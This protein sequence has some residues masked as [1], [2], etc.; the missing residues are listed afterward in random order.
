ML[1]DKS[2]EDAHNQFF[3]KHTKSELLKTFA[4]LSMLS[5]NHGKYNRLQIGTYNALLSPSNGSNFTLEQLKE[6]LLKEYSQPDDYEAP[7]N[8]FSVNIAAFN[9]NH[10]VF[11]GYVTSSPF[12]LSHLIDIV[13]S[14][15]FFSDD[16]HFRTFKN[17]VYSSSK[18]LLSLSNTIALRL[19]IKRNENAA[20][21]DEKIFVPNLD[22]LNKYREAITIT[23]DDMLQLMMQNRIDPIQADKLTIENDI[24]YDDKA[25]SEKILFRNGDEFIVLAPYHICL[26]GVRRII[27]IANE[28]GYLSELI[29]VYHDVVMG[30][31]GWLL[32]KMNFEPLFDEE[33]YTNTSLSLKE[34]FFKIDVDKLVYFLYYYDDY[35]NFNEI[36]FGVSES[37]SDTLLKVVNQ[38]EIKLREL[39]LNPK[40]SNYKILVIKCSSDLGRNMYEDGS[41]SRGDFEINLTPWELEV[42][43][44]SQKTDS[45]GIWKYAFA[46]KQKVAK[47]LTFLDAFAFYKS[48][49]DSFYW[50]DEVEKELSLLPGF[51]H[52]FIA[53]S[54]KQR[55]RHFVIYGLKDGKKQFAIVERKDR[56]V[57][58]YYS[59]A[60]LGR[61]VEFLLNGFDVPIWLET[62]YDF[63]TLPSSSQKITFDLIN[64]TAYWLW[65]ARAYLKNIIKKTNK[66]CLRII[67]KIDDLDKFSDDKLSPLLRNTNL[68]HKFSYRVTDNNLE[69]I[70]PYEISGVVNLPDNT[71][72]RFFIKAL[73]KSICTWANTEMKIGQEI[74]DTIAPLG[75]KK[76]MYTL[77]PLDNHLLW[78]VKSKIEFFTLQKADEQIIY[79]QL[80]SGLGK[81]RPAVG[82]IS[83]NQ[84]K[85]SLIRSIIFKVL[86]PWLKT[87]IDRY[88]STSLLQAFVKL[89]EEAILR[90]EFLKLSI[91]TERAC[92]G[93]YP[94]FELD[95]K[96][97]DE[98]LDKTSMSLRCLI[99]HVA[100][101]QKRGK[102]EISQVDIQQALALMSHIINFGSYVDMMYY[103][104]ED[105]AKVSI[106]VLR[107]GRVGIK[108]TLHEELFDSYYQEILEHYVDSSIEGFAG[109][110]ESR[111][112]EVKDDSLLANQELNEAFK[113]VNGLRYFSLIEILTNLSFHYVLIENTDWIVLTPTDLF[114]VLNDLLEGTANEDDV[115]FLMEHFALKHRGGVDKVPKGFIGSD[116]SPWQHN[117]RLSLLMR[118]FIIIGEESQQKIA[119]GPKQLFISAYFIVD[120]I[121]NGRLYAP[122]KSEL[123]KV[124]AKISQRE[125]DKLNENVYK[126]LNSWQI[127]KLEMNYNIYNHSKKNLKE[128]LGDV[129]V[130]WLNNEVNTI[131]SIECKDTYGGK[132]PFELAGEIQKFFK[133]EKNWSKKHLKRDEWLKANKTTLTTTFGM[134]VT[135]FRIQS[136]IVTGEIISAGHHRLS[137]ETVPI[138]N[139]AQLRKHGKQ[140]LYNLL[141]LEPL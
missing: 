87:I 128:D 39:K 61:K 119:F 43:F 107:S 13:F 30:N 138:F 103:C 110:F 82:E 67:L 16:D 73:L 118:P 132:N 59:K 93:H 17:D 36:S 83:S 123:S 31:C 51:A 34:S 124:I 14:H 90:R 79:D 117:R 111:N 21:N 50:D 84:E 32:H 71:A 80:L 89:N 28:H 137:K 76:K 40:W 54:L 116:I 99:E 125:N 131:F 113:K 104:S 66:E 75:F 56:F 53:E 102:T 85:Q 45:L 121:L 108:S 130:L 97:R 120:K 3:L 42:L 25:L 70:L 122:A 78:K 135:N 105:V 1:Q 11:P 44:D 35:E 12:W 115:T 26:S 88:D 62:V 101:D 58:L 127:G 112:L 6:F 106:N 126:L 69:F 92:F 86:L 81:D 63:Y 64:L 33:L 98:R 139:I 100:A 5:E 141:K 96:E 136:V 65:E 4:A 15:P 18:F 7:E 134:D 19:K 91:T 22:V 2:T 9:L 68:E 23:N 52:P 38:E 140:V 94:E 77:N 47:S 8:L 24:P 27:R 129:D 74:I 46:K 95:L 55:D 60:S 109:H 10:V 49:N 20:Y 114:N 48:K 72:D 133:E 57:P 37:S 29:S 41:E